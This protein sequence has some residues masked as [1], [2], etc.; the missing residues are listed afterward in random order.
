MTRSDRGSAS[1]W[2]VGMFSVVVFSA[3]VAVAMTTAVLARHRVE[4]SADLVALAGAE[5]IGR[6]TI[7]AEDGS[8][9][10]LQSPCAAADRT[11]RANGARL[12]GC[13]LRLDAGG[14]S[15]TVAVVVIAPVRL[16]LLGPTKATGRARAG[17]LPP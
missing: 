11:A 3:T 9:G 14:R 10:R 7:V 16:P 8:T 12:D 13:T 17:R 1:V 15:G 4:R 2:V 6:F 5:Q